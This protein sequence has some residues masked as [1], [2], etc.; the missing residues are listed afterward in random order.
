MV[1][2]FLSGCFAFN[3]ILIQFIVI[4]YFADHVMSTTAV[5]VAEKFTHD[6]T[7]SYL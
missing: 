2:K 6:E 1:I 3:A 7:G 4:D 5:S